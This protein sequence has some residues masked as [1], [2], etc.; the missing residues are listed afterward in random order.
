M[1]LNKGQIITFTQGDYSD[2]E[3]KYVARTLGNFNLTNKRNEWLSRHAT[4]GTHTCCMGVQT[5]YTP[6]ELSFVDWLVSKCDIEILDYIEVHSNNYGVIK[7]DNEIV[8]Y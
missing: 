6:K 8:M 4:K 5:K 2:Y 3:I 1:V 7:I